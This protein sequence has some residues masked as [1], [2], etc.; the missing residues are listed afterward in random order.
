MARLKAHTWPGN[1]RELAHGVE[2]ALISRRGD[3]VGPSDI[4]F[5]GG[6]AGHV[7]PNGEVLVPLAQVEAEHIARVLA[8]TG[9]NKRQSARILGISL[10]NLYRKLE[11]HE[12]G[13]AT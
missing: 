6:V 1:V 7:A 5:P 10:R 3:A 13:E 11:R 12:T 4:V 8:A 2:R 9:G